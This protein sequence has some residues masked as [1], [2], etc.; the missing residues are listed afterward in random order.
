M[1]EKA[2]RGQVKE[3]VREALLAA[4]GYVS[5]DVLSRELGC[6]RTAVWK[7]IAV[8]KEEGYEISSFKG[9]GY[10]L[11]RMA[12][13]LSAEGI[14]YFLGEDAQV[15][16]LASVSSTNQRAKAALGEGQVADGAVFA[17]LSQ[18][19]GRGRRGKSFFSPP[20]TGVYFSV[21]LRPNCSLEEAR[22]F[23][24]AAAAAVSSAVEE[25]FGT[26]LGIK[27]VNDL[28][29]RGK[30]V[31]GILTEAVTGFEAGDV[32]AVIVGIGLN[33]FP[34]MEGFP[35]ELLGI[36]GPIFSQEEKNEVNLNELVARI[37]EKLLLFSKEKQVHPLYKERSL[38]LGRQVEVEGERGR[39]K[40]IL[41]DG[42]LLVFLDTGE[43]KV[44]SHG[45][46]RLLEEAKEAGD[47]KA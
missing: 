2:P 14:R 40:K 36:A 47:G 39:A 6:S 35:E 43:E 13:S 42:R 24:T 30:K 28:F 16:V 23:T 32:E 37:T 5:G 41:P 33:I 34:P 3:K 11:E 8:L 10:R 27:W 12:H 7:A 20:G 17:S 9:S 15:E 38:C 46:L 4:E 25:L 21:V 26:V 22:L 44:F 45:E 31:G 1:T 29:L 19:Q 18:T